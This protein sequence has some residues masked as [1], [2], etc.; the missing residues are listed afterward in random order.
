MEL[1][2]WREWGGELSDVDGH[3][4]AGGS[5]VLQADSEIS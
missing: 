5:A 4:L 3:F 2:T 1:I